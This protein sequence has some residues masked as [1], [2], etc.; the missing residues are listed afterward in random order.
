M[1]NVI[2]A[3]APAWLRI[4]AALGL[5]WNL[6]GVYEYLKTVGVVGGADAAAAGAMPAWVTGAFAIAVFG[7]ALGCIGLLMLKR[8]C[9]LLLL[10]SLLGVLAM[11]LWMFVLSGLGGTMPTAEMAVTACV[12]LVAILLV[13]LAYSADK[14]GWLS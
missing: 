12:L 14:K 8:W 2:G 5:L 13:W 3:P 1:N 10:L 11:D 6:Y 4:V 9:K 7:G